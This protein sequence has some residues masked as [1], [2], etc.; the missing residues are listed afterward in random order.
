[1]SA[2]QFPKWHFRDDKGSS[3]HLSFSFVM[4]IETH[5]RSIVKALSYRVIGT[6]TTAL[7]VYAVTRKAGMALAAGGVD[8]YIPQFE[9]ASFRP[10]PILSS[11][12]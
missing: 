7:V 3:E 12:A 5:S 1:M 8:A 2:S 10:A 6:L 4:F 11:Y 9:R